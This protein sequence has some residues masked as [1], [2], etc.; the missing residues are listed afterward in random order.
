MGALG[1]A[2]VRLPE[3]LAFLKVEGQEPLV[4]YLIWKENG[5]TAWIDRG[6][7]TPPGKPEDRYAVVL[8][9][10]AAALELEVAGE[11]LSIERSPDLA[12][13]ISMTWR[14]TDLSLKAAWV[15][16]DLEAF[17]EEVV[18]ILRVTPGTA[19]EL[20]GVLASDQEGNQVEVNVRLER[21]P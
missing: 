4:A 21:L 7:S 13:P 8:E 14:A 10:R 12:D 9:G 19:P 15:A 2:D 20:A 3:G 5:R 1:H 17:G 18:G 6:E 11:R 16:S